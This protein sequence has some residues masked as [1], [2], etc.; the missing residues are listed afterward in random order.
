MAQLW[1]RIPFAGSFVTLYAGLLLFLLA[2]VG[3]GLLVSSL[4]ATMQQA[5]LFSFVILMPFILLSGLATPIGNMPVV[6]QYL[7]LINPLRYAIDLTHRVY[8]EGATI[9]QLIPVLWPLAAIGG[10]HAAVSKLDVPQSAGLTFLT[11]GLLCCPRE[12]CWK[13]AR[14]LNAARCDIT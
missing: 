3:I 12:G 1:F 13:S 10:G 2:A 4:V 8:L 9:G 11:D 5:M 14:S 6:F 7:T